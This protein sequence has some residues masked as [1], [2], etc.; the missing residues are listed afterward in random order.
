MNKAELVEAVAK[1]AGLSKTQAEKAVGAVT[2][3]ISG[4]LKKGGSVSLIGFGTFSVGKRA[5]RMGKNPKTGA[6]IK[7][8]ARKVAKFSA[9][10]GLKDTVNGVSGKKAPV[11]KGGK[12]K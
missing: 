10:K 5:A 6:A 3:S 1:A 7:I 4:E 2:G 12:K 8:A 11:K 9:G